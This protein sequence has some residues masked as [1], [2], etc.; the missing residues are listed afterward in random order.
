MKWE[1]LHLVKGNNINIAYHFPTYQILTIND[2]AFRA[3]ESLKAGRPV[4]EVVDDDKHDKYDI[5]GF[6]RQARQ[7]FDTEI[8]ANESTAENKRAVERITLHVSND[9]NLRC[10]Y[11]FADGGSYKQTRRLMTIQTA[12]DF[13]NFCHTHFDRIGEIVFFGGEPLMNVEVMEYICDRFKNYYKEDESLG[14]PR[15]CIITN[16]TL[17]TPR[18]LEFIK[19]NISFVTVS[20]D[21]PEEIN[22]INR[23]YKDGAGSYQK[24]AKF[25]R[26]IRQ[27]TDVRIQYEA[28]YTRAHIEAYYTPKDIACALKNEFGIKGLV[29]QEKGLPSK[30]MLDDLKTIDY[31]CLAKTEFEDL[32]PDFWNVLRAIVRKEARRT[33]PVV[34]GTFAVSTEGTIYPCQMLNGVEQ[35]SLGHIDRENIFNSPSLFNMLSIRV[36]LKESKKCKACWGQKL[37]GGC[38]VQRFYKEEAKEFRIDPKADLC[39]ST[40]QYL[41]QLLLMIAF[42][43][44]NEALWTALVEKEKKHSFLQ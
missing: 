10:K 34:K 42:I 8:Q 7:A 35:N 25:I 26:T 39:E 40:L 36:Q 17:M 23:M 24:I 18:I 37:C 30:L 21:G 12:E 16:G 32:P 14:M 28:T 2:R 22:D 5:A 1:D 41:E 20:I 33:C 11:C 3:L 29:I 43:R 15:F 27:E 44:K 9:C 6:I 31:A 4:S 13:V 38:T 19:E